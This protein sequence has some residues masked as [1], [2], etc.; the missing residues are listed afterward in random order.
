MILHKP[1][2]EFIYNQ[3]L[4]NNFDAV[5]YL[6]RQSLYIYL[7]NKPHSTILLPRYIPQ[8]VYDPVIKSNKKIIY[9]DINEQMLI[10]FG[11]LE[12][13]N[14]DTIIYYIHHF[15]LYIDQNIEFLNKLSKENYCIVDDRALTLPSYNYSEFADAT[16]YSLYKLIGVSYGGVLNTKAK[17]DLN[18]NKNFDTYSVSI[19]EKKMNKHFN[20]YSSAIVNYISEIPF[21]ILIKLFNKQLDYSPFVNQKWDKTIYQL[22]QDLFSKIDFNTINQKRIELAKIYLKLLPEEYLFDID[23]ISYLQQSMIGFVIQLDNPHQLYNYLMKNKVHSFSLRNGWILEN[24]QKD[25]NIYNKHL[26]LPLHH[27]I[28]KKEILEICKLINTFYKKN[29]I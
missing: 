28:D 16:L 3:N 26:I 25:W 9:Y 15:G 24:T 23:Q 11:N 14:K 7:I 21:K 5:N 20:F 13:D 29:P 18:Y 1:K 2:K 8:G 22:P 12:I 27:G 4:N 19:L 17:I 6:A 10:D